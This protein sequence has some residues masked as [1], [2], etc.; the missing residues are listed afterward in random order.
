MTGLFLS[1]SL[2]CVHFSRQP[3]DER[4]GNPGLLTFLFR[5]PLHPVSCAVR[6]ADKSPDV[7]LLQMTEI[8]VQS[9][10]TEK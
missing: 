3:L 6:S 9:N 2:L 5:F 4:T 10:H 8:E 1:C 7:L